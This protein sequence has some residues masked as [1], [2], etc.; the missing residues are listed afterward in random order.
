MEELG[1][2]CPI[3]SPRSLTSTAP[4]PHLPQLPQAP[5]AMLRSCPAETSSTRTSL[6][7]FGPP[8]PASWAPL[9]MAVWRK[10][11]TSFCEGRKKNLSLM[12]AGFTSPN[13]VAQLSA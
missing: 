13:E 10:I 6:T 8:T 3:V 11:P 1:L 2:T 9:G 4:W 12:T 5:R 7:P